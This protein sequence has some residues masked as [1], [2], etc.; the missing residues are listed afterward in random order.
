MKMSFNK[1][2]LTIMNFYNRKDR[3]SLINELENVIPHIVEVEVEL[4]I[5]EI[6]NKLKKMTDYEFEE[7][8]FEEDI[9]IDEIL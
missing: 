1:E 4:E 7:V 8:N 3:V 5:E 6:I 2:E 9:D